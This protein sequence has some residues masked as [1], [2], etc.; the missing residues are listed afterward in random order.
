MYSAPNMP[1]IMMSVSDQ[2]PVIFSGAD[3]PT[4]P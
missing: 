2:V 3:P 4:Y 1:D